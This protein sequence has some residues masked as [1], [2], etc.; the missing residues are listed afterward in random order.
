MKTQQIQLWLEFCQL[1]TTQGPTGVQ[2]KFELSTIGDELK[3]YEV[4]LK[5]KITDIEFMEGCSDL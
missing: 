3:R 5:N 4:L 1:S 2:G